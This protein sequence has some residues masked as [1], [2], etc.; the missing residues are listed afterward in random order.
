MENRRHNSCQQ[1]NCEIISKDRNKITQN[2]YAQY[3]K[4]HPLPVDARKKQRHHRPGCS[5]CQSKQTDQQTGLCDTDTKFFCQKRQNTQHTHFCID[6]TK[7]TYRQNKDQQIIFFFHN[8]S[9]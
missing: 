4:H 8:L 6:D 2:K 5:H 7:N 3:Q 9:C 1:H